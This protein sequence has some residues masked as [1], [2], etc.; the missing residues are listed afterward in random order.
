MLFGKAPFYNKDK[1][2]R[3]NN[4]V[5]AKLKFPASDISNECKDF[6]DRCL[7]KDQNKR[8][9]INGDNELLEHIWFKSID[10]EELMKFK[11]KPPIIPQISSEIDVSHFS[12]KFTQRRP[13]LTLMDKDVLDQLKKF[14]PL[15]EGFY[16]DHLTEKN[17]TDN[18]TIVEDKDEHIE[19]YNP[20]SYSTLL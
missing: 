16:Y 18:N 19:S 7:N 15:F 10:I 11:L 17:I 13:K 20:N 12:S 4:I 14:D 1:R 2:E 8:I 6:I 5:H 9:G 3:A